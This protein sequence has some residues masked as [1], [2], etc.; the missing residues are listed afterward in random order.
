MPFQHFR[1]GEI[2]VNPFFQQ[3]LESRIRI[4]NFGVRP[5]PRMARLQRGFF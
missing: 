1:E 4:D 3:T 5:N 2:G